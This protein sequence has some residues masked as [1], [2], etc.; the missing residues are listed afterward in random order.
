MADNL[1]TTP[2]FLSANT[3]VLN[4]LT[5]SAANLD[6][7]TVNKAAEEPIPLPNITTS[8]N[9][10]EK[11][12]TAPVGIEEK[13]AGDDSNRKKIFKAAAIIAAVLLVFGLVAG[14]NLMK[15]QRAKEIKKLAKTGAASTPI[16]MPTIPTAI[17]A[18]CAS[19][20]A[21]IL[22]ESGSWETKTDDEFTA[23]ARPGDK[24]R[25]MCTGAKLNGNFTKS[26]F[27][28]NNVSYVDDVVKLDETRFAV[29]YV[30][31]MSG[32]LKVESVLLRDK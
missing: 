4:S 28:I 6:Q 7:M 10:G 20:V 30:I 22:D 9:I 25:F 18:N 29:E 24:V 2:Q 19:L 3:A 21:Q 17:S 16:V 5:S 26:A 8:P 12:P 11:T 14:L 15:R 32:P 27:L 1:S 13:L 31:G 23:L